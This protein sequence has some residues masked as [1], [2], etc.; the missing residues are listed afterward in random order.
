METSKRGRVWYGKPGQ[1]TSGP[2]GRGAEFNGDR[3][4]LERFRSVLICVLGG[5]YECLGSRTLRQN[6]L[7]PRDQNPSTLAALR[8][9]APADHCSHALRDLVP[10]PVTLS[11]RA[12][13]VYQIV[14]WCQTLHETVVVPL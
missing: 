1:E 6:S 5:V 9:R 11:R 7:A 2:G 4:F 8:S 10:S 12:P 13:K 3:R 14:F